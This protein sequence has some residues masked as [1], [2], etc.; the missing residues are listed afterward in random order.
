MKSD[1][2]AL[3]Y[4]HFNENSILIE[5]PKVI[6]QSILEDLTHF[7]SKIKKSESTPILTK[8]SVPTNPY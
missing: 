1:R 4:H 2:Y 3:K 8:A 5:W 7:K 6:S